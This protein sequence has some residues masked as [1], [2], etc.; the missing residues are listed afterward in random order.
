MSPVTGNISAHCC[1][2]SSKFNVLL[3]GIGVT[4]PK[5]YIMI[6]GGLETLCLTWHVKYIQCCLGLPTAILLG[7]VRRYNTRKWAIKLCCI[8]DLGMLKRRWINPLP[9]LRKRGSLTCFE[10]L[11]SAK[12]PVCMN[13]STLENRWR[14]S[15]CLTFK[16]YIQC[17]FPKFWTLFMGVKINIDSQVPSATTKK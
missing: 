9:F 11:C 2:N 7:C 14:T 4:F 3:S 6:S 17:L 5:H 8:D 10:V 15:C 12:L 16:M 13:M 1:L